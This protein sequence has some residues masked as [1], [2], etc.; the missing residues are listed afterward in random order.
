MSTRPDP[1]STS[2]DHSDSSTLVVDIHVLAC[3][4]G[5][6][7]LLHLPGNVWILIDCNLPK[8]GG[9]RDRFFEFV[10]S[11]EIERLD[12]V[13]QTHPDLDHFDGMTEVLTYFTSKK[14]SVGYWCDGG[15]NP[16][17]IQA[18]VFPDSITKKRYAALH[19]TVDEFLGA[20][21][22]D[23]HELKEGHQPVYPKEYKGQ[24]E[25][26]PIAPNAQRNRTI[27]RGNAAR[28]AENP[29]AKLASN[30]LSVVLVLHVQG[31]DEYCNILLAADADKEAT[32]LALKAWKA[33]AEELNCD[34]GFDAIKIP[35]HGS[36]EE[37]SYSPDLCRVR[38]E[39]VDNT[40]AVVS[41]GRR[42]GLPSGRVLSDYLDEGWTILIT[43]TRH[44]PGA[45]DRPMELADRGEGREITF[46]RHDIRVTWS[47]DEGLEWGPPEAVIGH[48]D[49]LADYDEWP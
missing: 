5:D 49:Y 6:T 47:P 22:F 40:A 34:A 14:R 35:H 18:L 38:R 46:M 31:G 24:V 20:G 9:I 42:E 16:Q 30:E 25:L 29:A 44:A 1:E 17:Q 41:A 48:D 23:Y 39:D 8:A 28:M 36:G 37:D 7:I 2:A 15:V 45:F 10:K 43:T 26:Y 27:Q 4:H 32:D 13:V 33:E 3:D 21:T 19:R 11:N 12:Y